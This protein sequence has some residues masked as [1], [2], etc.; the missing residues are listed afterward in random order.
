MIVAREWLF[1]CKKGRSEYFI[2]GEVYWSGQWQF[3]ERED[4]VDLCIEFMSIPASGTVEVKYAYGNGLYFI[5]KDRLTDKEYFAY[6]MSGKIPDAETKIHI[7]FKE[8]NEHM[9][10]ALV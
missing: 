1:Y 3:K 6:T 10:G 8:I 5:P 9:R 4:H 2:S 7:L